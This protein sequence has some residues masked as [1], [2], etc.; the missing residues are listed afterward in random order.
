[1]LALLHVDASDLVPLLLTFPGT[2][3]EV[4]ANTS[5]HI[6]LLALVK[7]DPLGVCFDELKLIALGR[8][9]GSLD[10]TILQLLTVR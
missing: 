5:L 10:G 9:A 4:R 3:P 6:Q 7:A 8:D 2:A 1:M